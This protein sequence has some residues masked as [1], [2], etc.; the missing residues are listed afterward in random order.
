[1]AYLD[2][3]AITVDAVLTKK[4]RE[5][6]GQGRD[7]FKITKFAVADDEVD[8]SLYN[9]AHPL[10]SNYYSNIIESMPVLE[11]IP[12]ESQVMRYKLVTL[13]DA[14]GIQRIPQITLGVDESKTL[15]ALGSG[16]DMSFTITPQTIAILTNGDRDDT[17]DQTG[18]Y[19]LILFDE[20]AA[21]VVV[22]SGQTVSGTPTAPVTTDVDPLIN[23]SS[24]VV[25]TGFEF[26]ITAKNVSSQRNTK[27][28]VFGN[29]SG[30]TK[31][32]SLT[33]N[34]ASTT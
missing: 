18:G 10:G 7:A 2:N 14:N 29:E 26:R 17:F 27:I 8:Y 4:G 33:V 32:I 21:N 12:D 3:S 23:F 15:Y 9:S 34:P 22:P 1:M 16:G 20:D 28:T 6:L 31:T 24:T 30:A 13:Q 19:T 25:K 5:R 11:A